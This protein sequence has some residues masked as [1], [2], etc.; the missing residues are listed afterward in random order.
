MIGSLIK[1]IIVGVGISSA[2]IVVLYTIAWFM[3]T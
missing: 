2:V 1:G 3:W